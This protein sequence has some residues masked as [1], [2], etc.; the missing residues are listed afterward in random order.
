MAEK[1]EEVPE[2]ET[3]KQKRSGGLTILLA[4]NFLAVIGIGAFLILRESP[5][6][7][8]TESAPVAGQKGK[9]RGQIVAFPNF[10]VNLADR[11]TNRFIRM[12]VALE[13]NDTDKKAPDKMKEKEPLVRD[14][15]ITLISSM[16]YQDVRTVQGK[17]S[18]RDQLLAKLLEVLGPNSISSV[19]FTEFIVQ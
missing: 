16:T 4:I 10:L 17:Q 9:E 8:T 2:I 14:T 15:V 11:D 5:S 3:P 18:L 12:G 19:F 6:K 1:K 13:I 7:G